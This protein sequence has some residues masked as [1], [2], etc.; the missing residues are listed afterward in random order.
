MQVI[1]ITIIVLYIAV[2]VAF[3]VL[4]LEIQKVAEEA[5]RELPKI[6]VQKVD[7]ILGSNL[8]SRK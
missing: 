3:L 2:A 6:F 7:T 5:R 1:L 4:V 8:F